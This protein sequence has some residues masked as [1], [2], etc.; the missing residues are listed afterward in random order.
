MVTTTHLSLEEFHRL[1][2]G[3]K[4]NHEY[5]YG[6][7]IPKAMPTLL[8]SVVQ[9]VL[10]GI[11]ARRGWRALPELTLKMSSDAEP[12]PDDLHRDSVS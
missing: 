12:V 2:D 11:L 10:I 9:A 5:W 8:H 7:A 4:P 1:Y 6:E 3:V